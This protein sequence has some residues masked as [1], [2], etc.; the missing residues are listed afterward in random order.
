MRPTYIETRKSE[1]S[2]MSQFKNE[3][4]A[5]NKTSKTEF[6]EFMVDSGNF[7]AILGIYGDSGNFWQ[8]RLF[9]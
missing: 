3:L 1:L 5:T 8:F 4:S 6:W 7:L 2:K 9:P